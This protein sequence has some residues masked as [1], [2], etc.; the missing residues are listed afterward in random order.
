MF[1][2]IRGCPFVHV[3]IGVGANSGKTE[4]QLLMLQQPAK[5]DP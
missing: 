1:M 4:E 2:N 5:D 3:C